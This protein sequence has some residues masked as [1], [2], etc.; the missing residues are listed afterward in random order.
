MV[1]AYLPKELEPKYLLGTIIRII[2]PLYGIA[3]VGIYW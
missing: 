3:E 1:F 2:K